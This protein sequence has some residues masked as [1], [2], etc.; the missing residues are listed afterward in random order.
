MKNVIAIILGGGQGTRLYPLTLERAKPSVG[1]LGKYRLIDIPISN[2]INSGI[3]RMSVLTQFLSASLHRHIMHSYNFDTFTDGFVDILAAEQ[4]PNSMD[5][6][7]G[8]ADAVRATLNHTTYYNPELMLVLSGDHFYRMDYRKLINYHREKNADITLSVYPVSARQAP[9][10][11][12]LQVDSDGA[13]KDYIEKPSNLK[14]LKRFAASEDFIKID[15]AKA[16]KER[17]LASMGIYVFNTKILL[18]ILKNSDNTDFGKDVI[19]TAFNKYH[20]QAYP[21]TGYWKDV[22]TIK[23]FFKANL[24]VLEPDSLFPLYKSGWPIHTRTRSLPPCRVINSDIKDCLLTEGADI[25]GA[26]INHSIVGMRS[27]IRKGSQLNDVVMLGADFFDNDAITI[28]NEM[29]DKTIPSLGIGENSIIERA[30]I[31]KNVRI[32]NNVIIR[33]KPYIEDF[34]GKYFWVKDGIIVIPKDTVI[35]DGMD[36]SDGM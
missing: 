2:C 35:P 20:V 17:Y 10:F 27:N 7:Q 13:I 34:K 33:A 21:F 23:E 8:T 15:G 28:K 30:I 12:M 6:F 25:N 19:P 14:L 5:W 29:N 9:Q 1:F 24:T 36:F 4:T 22:G 3:K 18:D 31:D 16:G 32:G 11:G 26:Q